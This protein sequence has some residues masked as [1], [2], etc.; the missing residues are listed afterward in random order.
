MIRDIN[1]I[2]LSLDHFPISISLAPTTFLPFL[3]HLFCSTFLWSR[4][5]SMCKRE[6][7]GSRETQTE[8]V[9]S[10][11]WFNLIFFWWCGRGR[12]TFSSFFFAVFCGVRHFHSIQVLE[13]WDFGASYWHFTNVFNLVNFREILIFFE[14]FYFENQGENDNFNWIFFWFQNFSNF[15]NFSTLPRNLAQI[16]LVKLRIKQ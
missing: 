12:R 4:S 2:F 13:K 9:C 10:M 1:A 15:G 6:S 8:R 11:L 14:T 16:W 7:T 3:F 5:V